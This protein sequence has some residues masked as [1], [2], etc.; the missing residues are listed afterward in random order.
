MST[1]NTAAAAIRNY[2]KSVHPGDNPF[3]PEYELRYQRGRGVI[4]ALAATANGAD[5]PNLKLSA[6]DC[7][8]ALF[9]MQMSDPID[10]KSWWIEG[11]EPSQLLGEHFLLGAISNAVAYLGS[12]P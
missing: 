11:D 2:L 9:F 1:D 6:M 12:A 8:D 3:R 10:E 4:E 5:Y 7:S